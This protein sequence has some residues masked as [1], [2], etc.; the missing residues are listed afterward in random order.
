MINFFDSKI[1]IDISIHRSDKVSVLYKN[2][3]III[4][5]REECMRRIRDIV[6]NIPGGEKKT[7]IFK[8]HNKT[9]KGTER[10]TSDSNFEMEKI[11]FRNQLLLLKSSCKSEIIINTGLVNISA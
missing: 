8:I 3:D 11:Y 6:N 9:L 1:C 4:S 2:A 5:L 10:A 7:F